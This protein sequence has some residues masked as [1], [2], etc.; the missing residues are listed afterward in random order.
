MLI[1]G[2]K[3]VELKIKASGF[4]AINYNGAINPVTGRGYYDHDLKKN[5][6]NVI[7]PKARG[8]K[9]VCSAACIKSHL[10]G[11]ETKYLANMGRTSFEGAS[12]DHRAN[13]LRLTEPEQSQIYGTS[14]C[15]LVRGYMLTSKGSSAIARNSP[16]CLS[17]FVN[18]TET[19]NFKEVGVN[20]NSLDSEGKRSAN[21]FF[22]AVTWGDTEYTAKALIN[23]EELQFI[24][25]DNSFNNAAIEYSLDS[26]VGP[27]EQQENVSRHLDKTLTELAELNGKTDAGFEF[28]RFKRK[29]ALLAVDEFGILLNQGSIDL[30]VNETVRRFREL[31]IVKGKAMLKV[32]SVAVTYHEQS[33]LADHKEEPG[34]YAQFFEPVEDEL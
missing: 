9:M 16:L 30:F 31:L 23:I 7:F 5:M 6:D 3:Y 27:E 8:D 2:T 25:L 28:A 15:G 33:N 10:F 14:F 19:C 21:S 20:Q 24:S 26:N 22:H 1:S 17:D 18:Q 13:T 4:G 29:G 12:K 34:E 32:D 11:A